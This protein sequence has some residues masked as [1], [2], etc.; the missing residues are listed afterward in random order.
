MSSTPL[1]CSEARSLAA[2]SDLEGERF[3][4]L[5]THLAT[6]ASCHALLIAPR[7]AAL[8]A[9][10]ESL[11]HVLNA[12]IDLG[13][14]SPEALEEALEDALADAQADAQEATSEAS[15]AAPTLSTWGMGDDTRAWR[16]PSNVSESSS[17]P[18]VA[19]PQVVELEH[20]AYGLPENPLPE[21]ITGYELLLDAQGTLSG[22]LDAPVARI[23]VKQPDVKGK[24]ALTFE[25]LAPGVWVGEQALRVGERYALTDVCILGLPDALLTFEP[26]PAARSMGKGLAQGLLGLLH[27]SGARVR[28]HPGKSLLLGRDATC[29]LPLP[30]GDRV[31]NLHWKPELKGSTTVP[32]RG[33]RVE[34][35]AFTLDAYKIEARHATLTL[36]PEGVEVL[37]LGKNALRI[38]PDLLEESAEAE[39]AVLRQGA[40]SVRLKQRAW[41]RIGHHFFQLHVRSEA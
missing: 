40:G 17:F 24:A 38:A 10:A 41:L 13:F 37:A 8:N 23:E 29:D 22:T 20:S 3:T 21:L 11:L 18:A 25:A 27:R 7:E 9:T 5:Q 12:T 2:R 30:N 1:N 14:D 19:G 26:V 34:R 39:A 16:M 28:M 33:Q 32:Y 4:L 35:R 36:G 15:S 31:D 6:C